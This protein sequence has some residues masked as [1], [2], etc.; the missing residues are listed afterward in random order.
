MKIIETDL[1]WAYSLTQRVL[2]DTVII[3]HAAGNGSVEA[4]HNAHLNKGWAGIAY[5]YYVRKDG[6]VYRGRPE[7]AVG[8]HT[9]NE[10]YHTIGICFEGN[11]ETENM[12]TAQLRAGKELLQDIKS[13]Y[14][15]ITIKRHKDFSLTAC[16]GKNFPFDEMIKKDDEEEMVYE[17]ITDVPKY[18]QDAL[19]KLMNKGALVGTDI[20]DPSTIEDNI[21]NVN[22]TYCRIMTTLDRLGKLD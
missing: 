4:V 18:Y 5:H 3:H 14:P 15:D 13:R 12:S 8:G 20:G 6:S 17:K 2:T 16:P 21:I 1:K 10:N 9:T 7:W 19:I 11:F 22:E